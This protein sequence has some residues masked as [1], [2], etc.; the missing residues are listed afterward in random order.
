MADS[1]TIYCLNEETL[2]ST[3][4]CA[5]KATID[6]AAEGD[7]DHLTMVNSDGSPK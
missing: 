2:A 1:S 7:D 4:C 5:N 3:A 6:C